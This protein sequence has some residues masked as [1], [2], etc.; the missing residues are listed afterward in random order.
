MDA[1]GNGGVHGPQGVPKRARTSYRLQGKGMATL[2]PRTRVTAFPTSIVLLLCSVVLIGCA[3]SKAGFQ[4]DGSYL[5]DRYEQN[6]DCQ[7]MYKT[8]WGRTQVMK[9]LPDRARAEQK[10]ASPT[11]SQWFGR[12]F[13]TP[14]KGVPS[15]EEYDRERARVYALHRTMQ[16]KKCVPLDLET[17]LGPSNAAIEEIR[18]QH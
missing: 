12:W 13:G 4:K 7:S 3:S 8:I 2:T 16:E 5:L 1:A 11:A 17:E 9:A 14:G 18:R 15:I 6:M 10:A